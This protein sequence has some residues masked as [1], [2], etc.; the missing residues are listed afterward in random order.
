MAIQILVMTD[1][2][3]TL[4]GVISAMEDRRAR[5]LVHPCD[6]SLL[7]A[8]R[9]ASP[10]AVL[11]DVSQGSE[12]ASGVRD[13]MK[14]DSAFEGVPIFALG[15]EMA[16]VTSYYDDLSGPSSVA[17]EIL[18]IAELTFGF[19]G[20][21]DAG[22][23]E[24]LD[25]EMD[26]ASTLGPPPKAALA[27]SSGVA[28]PP[29]PPVPPPRPP[30][31]PPRRP[32]AVDTSAGEIAALKQSLASRDGE[33]EALRAK[34]IEL[35]SQADDGASVAAAEED[36]ARLARELESRT[37]T[38]ETQVAELQET[39]D[40][41]QEAASAAAARIAELEAQL[42]AA[43]EDT[44]VEALTEERDA[45]AAQRDEAISLSEDLEAAM[46]D[47][48]EQTE[49]LSARLEHA[50]RLIEA[51]RTDL[52]VYVSAAHRAEESKSAQ[53][54]LLAQLVESFVGAQ[55]ALESSVNGAAPEALAPTTWE[56]AYNAYRAVNDAPA[57]DDAGAVADEAV[58]DTA[59]DDT[60]SDDDAT[61][62]TPEADA[63]PDEG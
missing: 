19:Q 49:A 33:L 11:L 38:H 46:N 9:E 56:E 13:A 43:A 31:P 26:L 1:E 55:R 20:G 29:G 32:S 6:A 54:E 5:V 52:G 45:L 35:E 47:S 50:D 63:A 28:R 16:D 3:S 53:R 22:L 61:A 15:G 40:E 27:S 8:A 4:Q 58:A 2:A 30:G 14:Q 12:R 24:S 39:I 36:V 25:Q 10:A 62:E 57:A 42:E 60:A 17:A 21:D 34:I 51:L 37:G 59:P 41:Q 18:A 7:I 23:F 48:I 44:A